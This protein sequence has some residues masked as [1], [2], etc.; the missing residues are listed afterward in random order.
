VKVALIP[1]LAAGAKL[2]GQLLV[3][4]KSPVAAMLAIATVVVP[5]FVIVTPCGEL[6][7][8]TA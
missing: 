6:V 7:V 3:W 8:P 1:Q 4:A 2:A 5:M